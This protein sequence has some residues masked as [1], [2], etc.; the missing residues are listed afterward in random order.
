M[1]ERLAPMREARASLTKNPAH[2]NDIVEDG[3]RRAVAVTSRTME[4][5][6][7]AMKI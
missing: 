2:L 3:R 5:G 1:V 6:R 4:E 7:D